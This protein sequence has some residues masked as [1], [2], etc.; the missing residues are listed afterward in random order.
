PDRPRAAPRAAPP[1]QQVARQVASAPASTWHPAA[2][3]LGLAM[4]TGGGRRART[5]LARG[6]RQAPR[7]RASFGLADHPAQQVEHVLAGDLADRAVVVAA[8]N[9][10]A[11]DVLAVGWRLQ[12][13]QVGGRKLAAIAGAASSLMK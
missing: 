5:G 13:A 11:N 3:I 9:Q 10:A 12:A 6:A 8:C 2:I 1:A 7:V 4:R